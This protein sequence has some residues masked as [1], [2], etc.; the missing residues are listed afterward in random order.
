MKLHTQISIPVPDGIPDKYWHPFGHINKQQVNY[1]RSVCSWLKPSFALETGFCTGHSAIAILS[2]CNPKLFVSIDMDLDYAPEGRK[3]AELYM[4][5]FPN[6]KVLER[7]SK[8]ITTKDIA[9]LVPINFAHIDGGHDYS[10]CL[11][12]LNLVASCISARGVILVDDYF[13]IKAKEFQLEGVARAVHDFCNTH[14]DFHLTDKA[15]IRGYGY[16]V[17]SRIPLI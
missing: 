6:F 4:A 11:Y 15:T 7:D 2:S 9:D 1:I 3:M 12:D 13:H 17:L 16:A 5:D 8:E 14:T 10:T